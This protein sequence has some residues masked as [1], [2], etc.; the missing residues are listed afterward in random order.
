MEPMTAPVHRAWCGQEGPVSLEMAQNARRRFMDEQ[1]ISRR[2]FLR[3][4]ALIAGGV[5]LLSACSSHPGARASPGEP[6]NRAGAAKPAEA[7]KPAADAKPAAPAAAPAATQAAPAAKP[8][9]AKPAA[10]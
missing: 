10:G 8:A 1:G 4:S 2:K 6:A 7:A 9:D 5:T 3:I